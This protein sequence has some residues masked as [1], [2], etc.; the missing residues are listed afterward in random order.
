LENEIETGTAIKSRTN[1]PTEKNC[2]KEGKVRWSFSKF[3]STARRLE[4]ND[5]KLAVLA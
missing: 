1:F 5:G 4:E 2:I 3:L